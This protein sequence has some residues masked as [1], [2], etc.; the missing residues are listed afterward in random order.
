M[1]AHLNDLN[2]NV[3]NICEKGW[4]RPEGNYENWHKDNVAKSNWNNRGLSII[5]TVSNEMF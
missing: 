4:T 2:D 5:L 3:W 1:K